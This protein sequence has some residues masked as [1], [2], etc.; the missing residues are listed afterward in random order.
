MKNKRN[1]K[2]QKRRRPKKTNRVPGQQHFDTV[3]H[4]IE[5]V[6][7]SEYKITSDPIRNE[8]IE[9][10]P[11]RVRD[12]IGELYD[13]L[14]TRPGEAIS[15]LKKLIKKYP[16][17]PLFYNYLATAYNEIGDFRHADMIILENYK[18]NP[19][20]IFAKAHYAELCLQRGNLRKIPVIFENKF[21][22]KLLY[23]ERDIFHVSEVAAFTGITGLYYYEIGEME[24]A[25]ICYRLL[26]KVD[27]RSPH[28]KKLKKRLYPSIFQRIM[29]R[30][31]IY[32]ESL[33]S[34]R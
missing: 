23:P 22:L 1:L 17:I 6:F 20:Y 3:R 12:N 30:L 33:D 18:K 21:D 10:L 28:T 4:G 14:M 8:D 34:E 29:R 9:K 24:A 5:N 19:R 13:T 16:H 11:K 7:V 26:R 25:K 2:K 31:L 15:P 27:P 32:I